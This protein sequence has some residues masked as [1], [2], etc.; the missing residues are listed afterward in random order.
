ME[1]MLQKAKKFNELPYDER[2][3]FLKDLMSKGAVS[4]KIFEPSC[5]TCP[6]TKEALVKP[7]S[8]KKCPFWVNHEFTKN[9]S[10]N[11][12]TSLEEETLTLEQ[13]SFLFEK[14]L[15][16][17]ESLH[18]DAFKMVQRVFLRDLLIQKEVQRF[19]FIPGF[20]VNCQSKLSDEDLED[21][22]LSLGDGFGYCSKECKRTYLPDIWRVEKFFET[23]LLTLVKVGAELFNFYY[24][25][26]IL[27]FQPNVLRNRLEK[28][29]KTGKEE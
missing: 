22:Q 8:L 3:S 28:I 10:L 12:M 29:R 27:G 2:I 21:H 16:R 9:C 25:E 20:C 24:L 1:E 17:V 14:N 11:Y 5:S 13:I 19:N 23:D 6:Y 7:C 18:K 15:A 4:T 26:E